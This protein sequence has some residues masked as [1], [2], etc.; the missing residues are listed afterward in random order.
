MHLSLSLC[1]FLA[2]VIC[3]AAAAAVVK[4]N[5]SLMSSEVVEVSD[6]ACRDRLM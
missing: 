4:D 2:A 1:V 5:P 3:M 6:R